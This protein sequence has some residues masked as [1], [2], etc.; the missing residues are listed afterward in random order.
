M[1]LFIF[2]LIHL[3]WLET[4]PYPCVN[5]E[6]QSG[7][8]IFAAGIEKYELDYARE[9]GW[10]LHHFIWATMWEVCLVVLEFTRMRLRYKTNAN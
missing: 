4:W 6:I 7:S 9:D 5:G 2:V 8:S 1:Y 10:V 3:F